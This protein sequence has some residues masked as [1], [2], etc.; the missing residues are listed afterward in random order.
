[1]SSGIYVIK[2]NDPF[3]FY[4]GRSVN[5]EKRIK[6]HKR[7]LNNN[8][9][10]N[11]RMQNVFNKYGSESMDSFLLA[12]VTEKD[13]IE[14]VEQSLI[15]LFIDE[16]YC[17]NIN[18]TAGVGCDVPF[19]DER[20][21]RIAEK[22]TGRCGYKRSPEQRKKIS[23]A[24]MGHE[25][26]DETKR[27]ISESAKKRTGAKNPYSKKVLQINATTDEIIGEFNSTACAG[28]AMN[29]ASSNIARVCRGDQ[30]MAKGYK[31]RYK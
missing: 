1:M 6:D 11:P 27:K 5:V 17:L 13:L 23:D 21:R 16:D 19:T 25:V 10:K 31:W 2:F 8:T 9:H 4:I 14:Q 7:D 22:A 18:R 26:S 24:L 15:D 20:R 30:G 28:R 3:Y 29:C 12:K